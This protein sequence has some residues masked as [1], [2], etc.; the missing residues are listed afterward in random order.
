MK[1]SSSILNNYSFTSSCNKGTGKRDESGTCNRTLSLR[2]LYP[3][4][5]ESEGPEALVNRVKQLL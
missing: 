2:K 1:Q 4:P 5:M 3:R